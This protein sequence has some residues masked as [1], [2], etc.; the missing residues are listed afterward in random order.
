MRPCLLGG[1]V[2]FR[3]SDVVAVD[4]GHSLSLTVH[5]HHKRLSLV[6]GLLEHIDEDKRDE[7]HRREVVVVQYHLVFPWLAQMGAFPLFDG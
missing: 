1:L 4:A 3:Q 6:V 2:D 7:I 5:L